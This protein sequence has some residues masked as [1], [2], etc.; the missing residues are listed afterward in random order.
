MGRN[1][2]K[3]GDDDGNGGGWCLGHI[4]SGCYGIDHST[5]LE[6]IDLTWCAFY[7][8]G[9]QVG[10][11]CTFNLAPCTTPPCQVL[12]LVRL[13]W[14]RWVKPHFIPFEHHR[15]HSPVANTAASGA[16]RRAPKE[17]C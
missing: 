12:V 7:M 2:L 5:I 3:D 4:A 1:F 15:C 9:W 8:F 6:C 17:I 14:S 11:A 10:C 13:G 16:Y